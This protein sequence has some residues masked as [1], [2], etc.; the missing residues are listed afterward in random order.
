MARPA[1]GTRRGAAVTPGDSAEAAACFR[2][3]G[4]TALLTYG[5]VT[6]GFVAYDAV[7]SGTARRTRSL[8]PSPMEFP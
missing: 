4:F 7:G 6:Y 5:F 8:L 3:G 2:S 1:R